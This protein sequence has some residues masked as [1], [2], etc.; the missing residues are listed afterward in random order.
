MN[1]HDLLRLRHMLDSAYEVV[2][3][4][5]GRTRTDLETDTLFLRGISMSVG[6]IGEAASHITTDTH[7]AYS[8]IPWRQI[9]GMRHYLF[10]GYFKIDLDILW[11][12]ATL[13]IPELIVILE[14]IIST[15]TN[16]NDNG[17]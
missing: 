10:H 13:R 6:I 1:A 4:I 12:T 14:N 7:A 16:P 5:A 8:D 3:F 9:I 2:Q 17:E 15:N 11:A